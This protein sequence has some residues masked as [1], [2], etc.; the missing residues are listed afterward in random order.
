MKISAI[1]LAISLATIP[2]SSAMAQGQWGNSF[3]RGGNQ[4]ANS[5][6][7]LSKVFKNLENRFGGHQISANEQ[8]KNGQKVYIIVWM[9]GKGERKRFTV[10]ARTGRVL[11]SN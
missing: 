1:F 8:M 3:D 10:D 4:S 11:S 7:A 6:V 2:M 5:N 9:T